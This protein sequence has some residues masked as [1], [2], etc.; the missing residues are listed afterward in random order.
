MQRG[1]LRVMIR[2]PLVVLVEQGRLS[3]EEATRKMESLGY[4]RRHPAS[5]TGPRP[6]HLEAQGHG[7]IRLPRRPSTRCTNTFRPCD[8]RRRPLARARRCPAPCPLATSRP[9]M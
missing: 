4:Q 7:G 2:Y 1:R 6:G 8:L 3:Q 9:T 5:V